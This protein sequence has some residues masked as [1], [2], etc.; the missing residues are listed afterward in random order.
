[1]IVTL[2][3]Y[4]RMAI[5]PCGGFVRGVGVASLLVL[6]LEVVVKSRWFSEMEYTVVGRDGCACKY[7]FGRILVTAFGC[8]N[9][10][11]DKLRS[12]TDIPGTEGGRI[13]DLQEW[14]T[15]GFQLSGK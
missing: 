12:T 8:S 15:I 4:V 5:G 9:S 7:N 3:R 11:L 1:V 2:S 6:G 14:R 13:N 10:E